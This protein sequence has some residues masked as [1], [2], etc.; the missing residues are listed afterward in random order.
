LIENRRTLTVMSNFALPAFPALGKAN[1]DSIA[2][3][4]DQQ[5]RAALSERNCAQIN[6]IVEQ[7]K[8]VHGDFLSASELDRL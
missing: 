6:A 7:L 4:E 3:T 2:F 8:G 5:A 1:G